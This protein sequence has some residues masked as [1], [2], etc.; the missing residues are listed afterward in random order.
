LIKPKIGKRYN[1]K[2]DWV[3]FTNEVPKIINDYSKSGYDIFIISNQKGLKTEEQK[4]AWNNKIKQ[5]LNKLKPNEITV[6]AANKDDIF[7]K[8]RMGLWEKYLPLYDKSQSFYV[9]DAGGLPKRKIGN[10]TFK[11]FS[12]TD[13]KFAINCGIKFIH[14]DEIFLKQKINNSDLIPSYPFQ[15]KNI[16]IG[17]YDKIKL[18]NKTMYINVGYPGSGKSF[19]TNNYL[20]G[21]F[22][23]VSM[24]TLKTKSKCKKMC[25]EAGMSNSPIV[26][27]NTSPSVEARKYYID[28]A[29]KLNYK[30]V[31]HYFNTSRGLSIHNNI[32]RSTMSKRQ[33]V[34]QVA[35]NIYGS[36]FV[37]PNK[38][39]GFDKILEFDF[40]LDKRFIGDD[41]FKYFY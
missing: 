12:D 13:L 18:K 8:P 26:I 38:N 17:K 15:F 35:Y 7:R 25:A 21:K 6:L 28:I 41:Y 5:V 32:Y 27:D 1:D 40:I 19:F 22:V 3:F 37:K 10:D 34:P 24:D 29:K 20:T 2:H 11:D 31:C 9:G 39:E 30:V 33:I 23:L 16:K 36:K 14:R 4:K